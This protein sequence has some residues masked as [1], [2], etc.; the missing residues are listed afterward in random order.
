MQYFPIF[1]DLT[2]KAVLVIG[3]GEVASRK[4][5]MLIRAG[6]IVTLVSPKLEPAL[7][8]LVH[9]DQCQWI[10]NFYS[11]EL[12]SRDY[13]QVWATTNN[14]DLNHQVY[15]DAK[16]IGV[17]VNVVDDKPYCD[18]IT[19]SVVNRGKV[20]IA[21][22]SGGASPVLVKK[23]RQSIESVLPQHVSLLA[24]FSSTKRETVQKM[25]ASVEERRKFWEAFLSRPE[26]NQSPNR[27]Q[28]E[29]VFQVMLHSVLPDNGRISWVECGSDV[30]MLTLKSL[31]EMQSADKVFYGQ[32]C[33]FA[34]LD[35]VR[36]D[37]ARESY[38]TPIELAAKLEQA[39]EARLTVC[40][41]ISV[42]QYSDYQLL[43]SQDRFF[44]LGTIS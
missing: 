26:V 25:Y 12:L 35:L 13:V 2:H 22:S 23:I 4:V 15:K 34:F 21:I 29:K 24:E 31:Q 20:Q 27:E 38:Q 44:R 43:A 3:G 17:L 10:Q 33:E 16:R 37:A 5:E 40:V 28:L 9:N 6:A 41:L 36:R 19:P 30:E 18:F 32:E 14:P 8:E 7:L 42:I 1:V 11:S 39:R